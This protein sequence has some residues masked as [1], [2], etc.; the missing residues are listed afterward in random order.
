MRT[1]HVR[2]SM[3][4]SAPQPVVAVV[5]TVV[6]MTVVIMTVVIMTVVIMTVAVVVALR[7]LV[8]KVGRGHGYLGG[9]RCGPEA[10]TFV[11]APS[12][13]PGA[14]GA[15]GLLTESITGVIV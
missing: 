11:G 6:V 4:G 5:M 10:R 3:D 1:E 12:A 15:Q 9:F 8:M 14:P 7:A 2:E 13:N